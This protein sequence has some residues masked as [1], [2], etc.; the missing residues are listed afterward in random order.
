MKW[1]PVWGIEKTLE[2]TIGW[3]KNFYV[4]QK[5]ETENDIRAYVNDAIKAKVS[6]AIQ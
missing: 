1:K 5:V 4:S 6:W 2:K 3:Y